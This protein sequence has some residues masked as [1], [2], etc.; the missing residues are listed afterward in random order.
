MRKIIAKIYIKNIQENAERFK[1]QLG[2]T[3]LCAVVKAD[4]YGHGAE[5]VS[6]ALSSIADCF[7]VALLSEAIAIRQAVCGK[8]V[9]IFTPPL[10]EEEVY[11]AAK[12][13]FILTLGDFSTAK[14]VCQTAKKYALKVRV[15]LKANT[16]MNRYGANAIWLGRICTFLQNEFSLKKY[17]GRGQVCV[18]GLYSH[19]YAS[20]EAGAEKARSLFLKM[21]K[22]CERYYPKL[23]CHLSATFS[24][25][26]GK[27]YFFDMARVG[28]GLY[29]YFPQ[30]KKSPAFAL[31]KGMQVYAPIVATHEYSFG[32]AGYGD[33]KNPI[34]KGEKLSIL[35]C[36][37]ADGFLRKKENGCFGFER[38]ANNACMDVCVRKRKGK[39][40]EYQAVLTDAEETASQ[41]GTIA[42][43]VLCA[44]TRRAE[45]VYIYE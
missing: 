35:R 10:T 22:T 44:A 1:R 45:R 24:I 20:D 43:E 16:G 8:D 5:E 14:L 9:L 40:G 42:Y 30:G 31:K 34:K 26:L 6:L 7:A 18:E 38:N 39:K 37:Y 4:A 3:K 25:T 28:I 13:N 21:K 29:G 15:H 33:L 11:L 27:E 19:I 23:L 36:G 32:G 17:K 12:N 41:T 2:E